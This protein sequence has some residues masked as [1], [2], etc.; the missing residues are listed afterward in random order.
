MSAGTILG[1]ILLLAAS[2]STHAAERYA[3]DSTN[4]QVSF[5]V[6]HLGF[7]FVRARFPDINGEFVL[8]RGGA[9]SRV[10]VTVGIAT[11]ECSEPRWNDRLRSADWLDAARY[12]QMSYH[13]SHIE[14]ADQHAI[15]SGD[16][17]LHGITRPV[18]LT[19]SF[20]DCPGG[21]RCQFSA[22]G[23]IRRSEFGLPH[24]FWSGGD[25]VDIAISG[26]TH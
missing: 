12:P 13:S 14:V 17:T 5:V 24:G 20:L 7:Q 6:Q 1:W 11:L 23:R 10:D 16:L 4:T 3:L 26:T 25:Q 18:V 15:A 9:Q 8:D 19:V 21:G 22:H 2:S